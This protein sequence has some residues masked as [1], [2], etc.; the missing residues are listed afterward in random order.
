M[1]NLKKFLGSSFFKV[2]LGL[3]LAIGAQASVIIFGNEQF[4]ENCTV[5]SKSF[6]TESVGA[7]GDG[8]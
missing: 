1:S 8:G 3:L 7:L 4:L 5:D 6:R 2:S